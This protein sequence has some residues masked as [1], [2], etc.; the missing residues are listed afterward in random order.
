MIKCNGQSFQAWSVR[1][2]FNMSEKNVIDWI[3]I[4]NR[5]ELQKTENEYAQNVGSKLRK[6]WSARKVEILNYAK[7][8][9][10]P[11]N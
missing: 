2:I 11:E 9:V 5:L 7:L 10:L 6:T 4:L 3:L 1:G 8:I